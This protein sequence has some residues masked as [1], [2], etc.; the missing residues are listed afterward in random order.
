M[1]GNCYC[2]SNQL[3]ERKVRR[4]DPEIEATSALDLCELAMGLGEKV[5]AKAS[6]DSYGGSHTGAP[7]T[8]CLAKFEGTRQRYYPAL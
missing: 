4:T 6:V 5:K 7:D 8:C 3:A 1:M 2:F